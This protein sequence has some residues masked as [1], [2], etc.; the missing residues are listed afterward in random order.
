MLQ[1][2][3][4]HLCRPKATPRVKLNLAAVLPSTAE[5]EAGQVSFFKFSLLP[6]EDLKQAYEHWCRALHRIGHLLAI[7]IMLFLASTVVLRVAV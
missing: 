5:H 3:K 1:R 2:Q 4:L 7:K 6:D